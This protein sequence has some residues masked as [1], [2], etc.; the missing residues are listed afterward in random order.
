M[1]L[2]SRARRTD[3]K[4]L[5]CGLLLVELCFLDQHLINSVALQDVCKL[6]EF[7]SQVI[8]ISLWNTELMEGRVCA[9][10]DYKVQTRR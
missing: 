9:T 8:V 6:V 4:V 2:T 3:A 7:C 1:P 10:R 5:L